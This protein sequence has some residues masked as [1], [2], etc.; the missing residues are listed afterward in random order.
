[1]RCLTCDSRY[2]P[3]SHCA[4]E[5][6]S[7]GTSTK[8][9]VVGTGYVSIDRA[10]ALQQEGRAVDWPQSPNRTLMRETGRKF[11]SPVREVAR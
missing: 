10:Y 2:C 7:Q 1:M 8:A 5:F 9:Y 4:A 3:P 6:D 11:W